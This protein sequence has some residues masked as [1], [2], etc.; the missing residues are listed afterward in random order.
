MNDKGAPAVP[1]R[2]VD[3]L[4]AVVGRLPIPPVVAIAGAAVI[5]LVTLGV[6]QRTV[7]PHWIAANLDSEASV[8]TGVSTVLLWAASAVWF[9]VA[10]SVA[11]GHRASVAWWLVL[12]WL[13]LDEG[14]AFHER[15]ERW[16]ALDWQVL[17]LP[18]LGLG[19]AA[20]W[21]V[22]RRHRACTRAAA[23]LATAAVAWVIALILELAQNWGGEPVAAW[24]YDPTMILEEGLEMVGSS[25]VIV[26]GLVVLGRCRSIAPPS[27]A[28]G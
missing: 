2:R 11:R 13:A 19:A 5:V 21:G 8:G 18:I 22:V 10:S 25:A 3:R 16:L 7:Y 26:A 14:N 17:Y 12:A 4:A 15:V 23:G 6:L 24:F 27:D 20:W 9:L 28:A 1:L